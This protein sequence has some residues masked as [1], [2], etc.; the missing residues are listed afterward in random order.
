[1]ALGVLSALTIIDVSAM[2][3]LALCGGLVALLWVEL[4]VR[5]RRAIVRAVLWQDGTWR[6][7]TA[8]AADPVPARLAHHWGASNG[9][10]I[11]LEW[12]CDDGRRCCAWL[13]CADFPPASCRRLRVRLR[14]A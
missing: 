5:R 13:W 6:L 10:V 4:A 11:G 12:A 9:P 2:T 8:A 3:R 7:F 1:V 14:L